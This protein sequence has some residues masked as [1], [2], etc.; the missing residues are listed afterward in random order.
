MEVKTRAA[1]KGGKVGE[2]EREAGHHPVLFGNQHLGSRRGAEQLLAEICFLQHHLV[3]Q[4]FV[5]R[6]LSNEL[7]DGGSVLDPC[8]ANH[9]PRPPV[10]AS[11][12]LS[13]LQTTKKHVFHFL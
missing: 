6:E 1:E 4:P 7:R 2:V 3:G 10:R 9:G 5:L 13:P 11:A 12:L 8:W